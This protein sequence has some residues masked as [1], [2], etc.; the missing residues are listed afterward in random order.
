MKKNDFI[1][2]DA[3]RNRFSQTI[4]ARGI[5]DRF[6]LSMDSSGEHLYKRGIKKHAGTAPLRETA[7]AAALIIAGYTGSDPLI[8]PMCGTGTFALEAALMAKNIPPGWFRDFAF[9]GWPSY[10]PKRW[11][12]LKSQCHNEFTSSKRPIIW[13]S[14]ADVAAC[15]QLRECLANFNLSDAV[16]VD[17]SNFFDLIPTDLTDQ[18]GLVAI[19]PPYGRRIGSHAESQQLY[20]AICERL[21]QHYLGWNV[22]LMVPDKK[23]AKRI[24]FDLNR[25]PVAHGGLK[26]V[27]MT[28]RIA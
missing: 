12:Y 24:P 17:R 10:R 23:Q 2:P 28:G 27:L 26:A 11:E 16:N 4:Y 1:A 25:Y 7:A 19:N 9:M 5:D 20:K 18:T 14:D 22:V 13:A 3:N 6:T 21:K 15:S 8:D